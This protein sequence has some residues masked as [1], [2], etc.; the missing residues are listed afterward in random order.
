MQKEE[1]QDLALKDVLSASRLMVSHLTLRRIIGT[2][3]FVLPPALALG[4]LFFGDCPGIL[5][6]ISD[7]YDTIMRDI[8]VGILFTMALFFF[9][10]RG[11]DQRDDR[12]GDLACLFAIGVA[13]C[14]T[15]SEY[16]PVAVLH[17]V[18]AVLL[19]GTLA[20]FSICLF[21]ETSNPTAM[22]AEKHQRNRI[23]RW[24][25]YT[26]I[27][28]MLSVGVCTFFLQDHWIASL[29][30]V[31]WLEWLMLWAFGYSW[32]VKGNTYWQDIVAADPQ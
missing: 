4:C 9:S 6:T 31:F 20:Y 2:M 27:F 23:Y 26:M 18:S 32:L 21:T 19:F 10:Y 8:F 28:C 3:G 12:A 14:P 16:W 17:Y 25:G 24:C 5:E 15:N 30:P 22:T 11:Y 1:T 7:Y 13:L 29:M